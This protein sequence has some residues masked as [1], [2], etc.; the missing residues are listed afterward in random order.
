MKKT[1]S[2]LTFFF[3]VFAWSSSAWARLENWE[4]DK[5]HSGIYFDVKH[6]FATIRGFFDDFSGTLMIDPSHPSESNVEFEVN[7]DSINTNITK[8]DEHLKSDDFFAAK[9]FPKMTFKSMSVEKVKRDRYNVTG[10][11]TI[12]GIT[13]LITVP[14]I[15]YGIKENPLKKGQMVGGFEA[16]FII[17]R[18][19]YK[20][21]TGEF[22]KMGAIGENVRIVVSLEV[23]YDR[24]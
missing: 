13:K 10:V 16:E 21:G 17:N 14:F 7:V 23:L 9:K 22:A 18:L 24:K 1:A 12:K 4:I 19:D 20:I 2:I 11:L 6:T 5:A 3:C 15:Y 8:R